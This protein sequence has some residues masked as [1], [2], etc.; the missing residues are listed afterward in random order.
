MAAAKK[1]PDIDRIWLKSYPESVPAEIEPLQFSSVAELLTSSCQRFADRPAYTCMGKTLSYREV[2]G[3]SGDFAAWLQSRNLSKGDRV[4]MMV[5][6][7]LQYPV[8]VAGILR[9]GLV[10]VNMAFDE[11]TGII[12]YGPEIVSRGFVFE[13]ETGHL[14]RDAE[15]VILEVVEDLPPETKNRVDQ[16]RKKVQTALR[17]YF[18]YTI[19][20]RPMI[21]PFLLEV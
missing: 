21:L 20:R 5:P 6:N 16:I 10:V 18:Y 8:A 2:E 15:C 9:A 1:K 17:Q 14:L 12:V 13:T 19:K 11:E 4:A 3:L 7:V